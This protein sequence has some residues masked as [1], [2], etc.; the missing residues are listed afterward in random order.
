[1]GPFNALAVLRLEVPGNGPEGVKRRGQLGAV[2]VGQLHMLRNPLWGDLHRPQRWPLSTTSFLDHPV[3]RASEPLLHSMTT[4]T[5]KTTGGGDDAE[6]W[7]AA[8]STARSKRSPPRR[9]SEGRQPSAKAT[10][11]RRI[12][13]G[14]GT[15]GATSA[16]SA[17]VQWR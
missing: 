9:R 15:P 17:A 2:H 11:K 12:S 7:A 14:V 3:R 5:T 6:G 8:S 16:T 10:R 13:A 4:T 1:M